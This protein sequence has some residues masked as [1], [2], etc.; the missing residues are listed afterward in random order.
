MPQARPARDGTANVMSR[1]AAS[2]R[3]FIAISHRRQ[4]RDAARDANCSPTPLVAARADVGD[5][6]DDREHNHARSRGVDTKSN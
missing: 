5:Q 3:R 2:A 6:G 4:Y 1:T